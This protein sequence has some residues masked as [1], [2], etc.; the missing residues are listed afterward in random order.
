MPGVYCSSIDGQYGSEW[1]IAFS[2]QLS[3]GQPSGNARRLAVI[4]QVE[5]A[6]ERG[7]ALE[8]AI[9]VAIEGNIRV[10]SSRT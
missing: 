9:A 3:A 1:L 10:V 2:F 6:L 8:F 7:E 4:P 5:D